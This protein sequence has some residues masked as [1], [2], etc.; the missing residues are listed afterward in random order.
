M[1]EEG[2]EPVLIWPASRLQHVADW[3]SFA[4]TIEAF[5]SESTTEEKS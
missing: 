2:P 3:R 5:D 1:P 4:N